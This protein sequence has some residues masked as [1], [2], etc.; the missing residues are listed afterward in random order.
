MRPTLNA[1]RASLAILVLAMPARAQDTASSL[2]T[3]QSLKSTKLNEQRAVYVATPDN[4]KGSTERYPVLVLLDAND[5]PQFT[6]AVANVRFLASRNAIPPL[7]VVGIPNGKDRTHDMT[8][9][10]TGATAKNF[11]TAGGA[12]GLASF[13]IDEVV[14]LI[15]S[16]YR[17]LPTTVLAGHSFG[18]LFALDVAA[19]RPGAF[20]GIVAMSPSI[21]W[22]D[23]TAALTYA[24]VI[25]KSTTPLRLFTTSGGLEQAIDR[26]TRLFVSKLDSIKPAAVAYAF[27]HY[28]DDTH[29]LTPAPSLMDGL[30]FVFEPISLTK[31]P[32]TTALRPGVDSATVVNA[33]LATE[34]MYTDGARSLGMPDRL[35]E[36][37]LNG[38]AYSVLRGLKQPNTAL[39]IFRRNAAAYPDSPNV[40]D[41]LGDGLL[42]VGDTSAAKQQFRRSVEV[43]TRTGAPALATAETRKKLESL[44]QTTQAGKPKP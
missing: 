20:T 3:Q 41:S 44:E 17:T 22:N 2:W 40:Y 26:P 33:V 35:P 6:S 19:T 34:K 9:A 32:I 27:R 38:L 16:Q 43:A 28:P 21:W 8:P 25:G 24:N 31:V 12:S 10:A 7:I 30:R 42:A 5:R 37:V 36:S 14:P 4:Y 23:T 29:G 11:A 13:I 39:V 15:R 1:L 18:G